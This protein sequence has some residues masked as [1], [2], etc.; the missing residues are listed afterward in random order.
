M[1]FV[2]IKTKPQETPIDVIKETVERWGNTYNTT[3]IKLLSDQENAD[4][5]TA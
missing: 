3:T 5:V 2:G 4:T 1:N